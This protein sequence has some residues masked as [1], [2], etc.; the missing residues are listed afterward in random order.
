MTKKKS[1]RRPRPRRLLIVDGAKRGYAQ[2]LTAAGYRVS[3]VASMKE[4]LAFRPRPD[5]LI[6]EFL[7]PDGELSLLARA[8][9]RR[10]MRA[11]TVIALAEASQREAVLQAGLA[12]CFAPCPPEELVAIVK[13]AIPIAA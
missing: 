12:F 11:M 10:R 6:V 7:V 8:V 13:R 5:G 1:G 4:A 2:A 9:K 3:G